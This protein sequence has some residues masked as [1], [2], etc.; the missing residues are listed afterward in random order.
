MKNKSTYI[1]KGLIISLILI[2]M[3][4]IEQ[5]AVSIT[6]S[7]TGLPLAIGGLANLLFFIGIIY[8]CLS[9]SKEQNNNVRFGKIF[10]YGFKLTVLITIIMFAYQA[11]FSYLMYL[12]IKDKII[13]KGITEM[14]KKIF[15]NEQ[16]FQMFF[17]EIFGKLF[18]G[19]IASLIGAGFAKKN[20][21]VPF[22]KPVENT[23]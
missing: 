11:I 12:N 10:G 8:S 15:T 16:F 5:F 4:L 23:N 19:C 1:F 9:Y 21:K 13:E 14:S 18:L 6:K 22:E 17:P 20:R 3:S 7:Y 2:V